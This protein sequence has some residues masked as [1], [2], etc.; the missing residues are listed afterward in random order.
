MRL[1]S[2]SRFSHRLIHSTP[3]S[4]PPQASKSSQTI[5]PANF[6]DDGDRGLTRRVV[7]HDRLSPHDFMVRSKSQRYAEKA[8]ARNNELQPNDTG[9]SIVSFRRLR[10]DQVAQ[11]AAGIVTEQDTAV[12]SGQSSQVAASSTART[13]GPSKQTPRARKL[14][15]QT[16]RTQESESEMPVGDS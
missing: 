5:V 4:T 16:P 1:H 12:F 6:V 7:L 10:D 3:S 8:P 2:L 14:R 11:E 15:G 9:T 13:Y